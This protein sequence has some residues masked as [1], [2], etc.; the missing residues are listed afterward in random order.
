MA[1]YNSGLRL[2]RHVYQQEQAGRPFLSLEQAAHRLTGE[3]GEWFGIDAGTLREG[4]RADLAIIDPQRLDGTLDEYAEAPIEQFGGM[5][6]MVNRND[7]A[8][9]AVFIGGRKVVEDGRLE[10]HARHRTHR[11]V[12]ARGRIRERTDRRSG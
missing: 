4:D 8:V 1:F 3:L 12:S 2:L 9:P 11:Q 7:A 6:R 5:S 10:R